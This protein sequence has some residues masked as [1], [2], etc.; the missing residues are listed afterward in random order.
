M[1]N[2]IG[3]IAK[4]FD[5]MQSNNQEN[6]IWSREI[7]SGKRHAKKNAA[8]INGVITKPPGFKNLEALAIEKNNRLIWKRHRRHNLIADLNN[9]GIGN[10]VA[11]AQPVFI[12]KDQ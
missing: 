12:E 7:E 6:Y 9:T 5:K 4:Q 10:P 3:K 11:N 2:F 1:K 8:I